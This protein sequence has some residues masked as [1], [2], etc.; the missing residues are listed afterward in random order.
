MEQQQAPTELSPSEA[1]PALA[2]ASSGG[3]ASTLAMPQSQASGQLVRLTKSSQAKLVGMVR[4]VTYSGAVA[5][6]GLCGYCYATEDEVAR[7]SAYGLPQ[8][9]EDVDPRTAILPALVAG[10]A[11][12]VAVSNIRAR[13]TQVRPILCILA[14]LAEAVA[15]LLA[16]HVV[17]GPTDLALNL[18][19]GLAG[20]T[21][22]VEACWAKLPPFQVARVKTHLYVRKSATTLA[23]RSGKASI[24]GSTIATNSDSEIEQVA[25]QQQALPSIAPIPV[26]LEFASHTKMGLPNLPKEPFSISMFE[27]GW[28]SVSAWAV[29]LLLCGALAAGLLGRLVG[30]QSATHDG[31]LAV[32][33][34]PT[35][36]PTVSPPAG[37]LC[38]EVAF[39]G[40]EIATRWITIQTGQLGN[41]LQITQTSS[42]GFDE[43]VEL[44]RQ[45]E[46]PVVGPAIEN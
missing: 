43:E 5:Y 37:A 32:I 44:F 11:V 46:P 22:V 30:T 9:F 41:H 16:S 42:E 18:T 19:M 24:D 31:Q 15:V 34:D 8:Y 13:R 23:G 40:N 10:L 3:A 1:T 7:A 17:H 33:N 20:L 27:E 21:V 35:L 29:A 39:N 38:V 4:F 2:A 26:A 14:F 36:C 25:A 12:M 45:I 6:L 28:L